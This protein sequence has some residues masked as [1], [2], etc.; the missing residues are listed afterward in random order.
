VIRGRR[1]LPVVIAALLAGCAGAPKPEVLPG[2]D[3][4]RECGMVI[5]R[6]EQACG[7][8]EAG[9][10]VA[11]DSPLC[12]LR[13]YE[14]RP[15]V[16]RPPANEI[17]FADYGDGSMHPAPEMTFLLT[18]HLPTVMQ[19]GAVGFARREDAEAAVGHDD[20]RLTDWDGYRLA[21]G[22]P[23]R[24]LEVRFT[25]AGLVPERVEAAKGELL[26]WK[27]SAAGLDRDLVV[28]IKGYP[29][30]GEITLPASGE[31]VAFRMRALRPGD[32]FPIVEVASGDA[33]GMLRVLGSHTADE[34][35]P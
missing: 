28:S 19:S 10:F 15:A 3:A 9:E 26:L 35:A 6:A 2:V 8:I 27:A 20:E 1:L 18:A 12:L 24:V 25:P 17:Y 21:H 11:F 29:E 33:L 32:G 7:F 31:E 13:H 23:D 30:L 16:S 14:T 34:E 22:T 4:C 5:D